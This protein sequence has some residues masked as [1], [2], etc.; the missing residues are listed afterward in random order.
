MQD[1]PGTTIEC[2]FTAV[3]FLLFLLFSFK[4]ALA[5]ETR[6]AE[7]LSQFINTAITNNPELKS[8]DARWRMFRNRIAQARSFEDPLLML[9]YQ[10]GVIKYPF[11]SRKDAMTHANFFNLDWMVTN[12]RIEIFTEKAKVEEIVAAIMEIAHTSM[13]GDGIG[14]APGGETLPHPYQVRSPA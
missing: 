1:S 6:P 9:K 12:S 7:N 13:P 14:R 8:S 4:S 10:N 3:L 2:R 5:E 11:D